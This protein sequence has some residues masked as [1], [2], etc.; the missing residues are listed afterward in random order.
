MTDGGEPANGRRIE[1][2]NALAALG[3]RI[4]QAAE[5]AGRKVQDIQLLPITKFFPATDVA[6]L[7]SLGCRVFGESRDQE[8]SAKIAALTGALP[9]DV[10]WHM[11]GQI[12]RNK[13]RSIALWA[14]VAHSVSTSRVA[15][16]LDRAVVQARTE[17]RRSEPMGV[18]V[19]I[20]LDGDISRGGVD[21]NDPAAVDDLC[22]QVDAADG[23]QFLGLMAVPPRGADPGA[24]FARLEVERQ[25]VQVR[26]RQRLGLSAGM[27]DD[28][29]AAVK[30]GSTCLRVGTA[31]M[32]ARPLTSP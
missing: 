9:P 28:L 3:M 7:S 27:S 4:S 8:A 21:V 1:L 5:K 18:F 15:A 23:L 10:R 6:I 31:L 29:E 12:Q 30:H 11:V 20:S 26:Y 16:A 19:Q 13:A 17:G 24:A 25:R 14:D 32:G 22:A 2:T